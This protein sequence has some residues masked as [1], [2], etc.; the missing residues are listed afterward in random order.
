MSS[1]ILEIVREI[2]KSFLTAPAHQR[3]HRD[4]PK[5]VSSCKRLEGERELIEWSGGSRTE[6]GCVEWGNVRGGGGGQ[7]RP[8]RGWSSHQW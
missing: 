3:K 7:I 8:G 2:D 1:E 5:Q 4:P 6:E